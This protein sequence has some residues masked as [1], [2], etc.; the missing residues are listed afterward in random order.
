MP[1]KNNIIALSFDIEE[2][3]VPAESGVEIPLDR[4]IE[5]STHGLVKILEILDKQQIKATFFCTAVY[6]M[7]KPE[8]IKKMI[9]R[10]H[11]VASHSF[12]HSKFSINDIGESKKILEQI[13][14]KKVAGYRSPRMAD[15]NI[16]ELKKAGYDWDSSLNPCFLPG[17]YNNFKAPRMPHV[18]KGGLIELPASVSNCFRI[19]L[20]WLAMHN[21]PFAIYKNMC[22]RSL[23]KTGFLNIYMH[24]WEFSDILHDKE[25]KI[26]FIIRNNS[27]KKLE[28][29]L[30]RFIEYFKGRG[31]QFGTLSELAEATLNP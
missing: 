15:T 25:L 14:G 31:E 2:F 27:G 5:I 30:N 16:E 24:P 28:T 1:L 6:A 23:K 22:Q 9:D 11:E 20:F 21:L 13:T 18:T 19:P 12:Y 10:G 17:R 4:Q 26:P 29:K 7:A 3:D 8:L